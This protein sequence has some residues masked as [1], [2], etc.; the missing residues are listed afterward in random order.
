MT[1]P[2]IRVSFLTL[3]FRDDICQYTSFYVLLIIPKDL[4]KLTTM[5]TIC[6]REKR[7]SFEVSTWSQQ[8][9]LLKFIW[10]D[11]SFLSVNSYHCFTGA[12]RKKTLLLIWGTYL[13]R[14]PKLYIFMQYVIQI[15]SNW[16]VVVKSTKVN[17]TGPKNTIEYKMP[18][19]KINSAWW[20][21][22]RMII[23]I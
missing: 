5:V 23:F 4:C 7:Q 16:T 11:T 18:L 10:V 20:R 17:Y 2:F 22:A 15:N 6:T 12:M 8:I 21:D 19:L 14:S 9:I 1:R 13:T 3:Y